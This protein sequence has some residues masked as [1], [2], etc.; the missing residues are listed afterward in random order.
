M[1]ISLS[2]A[3]LLLLVTA[4]ASR[5]AVAPAPPFPGF[6]MSFTDDAGRSVTVAGPP[7]RIVS[8]S[9]GTTELLFYLGLEDRL[10]GVDDYSDYPSAA[11]EKGKVGGF[12]NTNLERVVALG[13]DLVLAANI[14]AQKIVPE[15]EQRGLRVVVLTPQRLEDVLDSLRLVGKIGGKEAEAAR[16]T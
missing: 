15:L 1:R 3:A 10:V 13:P 14:H 12:A 2:A 16:A 6:P 4:C 7:Q 5:A 8:L 11:K 9:P